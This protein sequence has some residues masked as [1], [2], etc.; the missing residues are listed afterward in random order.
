MIDAVAFTAMGTGAFDKYNLKVNFVTGDSGPTVL[1]TGQADILR[2]GFST[3]P[4]V[5]SQG[6]SVKAFAVVAVN[7]PSGLLANNKIKSIQDLAAKGSNCSI[8]GAASGDFYAYPRY[9]AN[10]YGLK[11]K[12]EIVS[13]YALALSGV[14][15]GRY[16]A[17]PELVSNAGATLAEKKAHWIIDPTK[18][19]YATNGDKVPYDDI[20][21]IFMT[22]TSYLNSHKA[23]VQRFMQALKDTEAKMK[24][25]SN[26]Q[27]AQAIKNSGAAYWKPQSVQQIESQLTG[28]NQAKNVFDLDK[29][30][31]QGLSE[32]LYTAN[33]NAAPSEGISINPKDPKFA[34]SNVVDN[35]VLKGG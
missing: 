11:C 19:D 7:T 24:T 15:A 4:L 13:N 10:K 16:D 26:E 25:M 22:T 23:I 33:L 5:I 18:P 31:L 3:A 27:I 21:S 9:W 28:S 30:D 8:V 1:L 32:S 35:T 29:L 6:K 17:A 20:S 14:V 2:A 12:I 34:Y